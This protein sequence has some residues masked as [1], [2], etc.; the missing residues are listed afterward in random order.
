MSGREGTQR[1]VKPKGAMADW[2]NCMAK[3]TT[4]GLTVTWENGL[5]MN[6]ESGKGCELLVTQMIKDIKTDYCLALSYI[7]CHGGESKT[8]AYRTQKHKIN[9]LKKVMLESNI[10]NLV[11]D[12]KYLW[13]LIVEEGEEWLT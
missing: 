12:G 7:H 9:F 4:Q 13:R 5:Q 3:A 1:C 10:I 8:A 11:A 2:E 6:V